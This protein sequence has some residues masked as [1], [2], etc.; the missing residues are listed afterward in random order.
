[1]PN[2]KSEGFGFA[3]DNKFMAA[4]P[5]SDAPRDQLDTV[6]QTKNRGIEEAVYIF[7]ARLSSF[8]EDIY[9]GPFILNQL[10][11]SLVRDGAQV[12]IG[13]RALDLLIALTDRAGEV[14]S[15]REL[16][17]SVWPRVVVE[18]AN[19]RVCVAAL[20]KALG[21]GKHGA[22]YIVNVA[23]RGYTFVAPIR[24]IPSVCDRL[25]WM[26]REDDTTIG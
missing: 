2:R 7:P 21:D 4:S 25:V 3:V 11:R 10:S 1:M 15:G 17:A 8:R 24:R 9:F 16:L 23:G 26:A 22:R 12:A 18:D 20:R 19:L 5:A 14:L 13:G 6:D